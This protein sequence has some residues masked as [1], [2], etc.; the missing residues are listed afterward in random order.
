MASIDHFVVLMLENRSFDHV[1]GLR[2][3]VEGLLDSHGHPHLHNV[4]LGGRQVTAQGGAP[5][6][7]PTKH[8]RGPFHN[9][10]DV[11]EQL[12]ANQAAQ[13]SAAMS[14]FV[15]SYR[16]AL[17]SDTH[18]VFSNADVD[19]VMQA[20]DAASLPAI[21]ALADHFVLCD[22]WFCEVP[23]PTHPNRLY[24]HAGTSE[25]FAHN[26]FKR[27]FDSPTIYDLLDHHQRSW[28]VYDF[29]LNEVK[30]F[31]RLAAS[32]QNFRRFKPSFAQ[33]VQTGKLPNYSFIMPRY[34][35]THA[36]PQ[37]DQHPPADVR[38]G[39]HLI[40]DVY[41]TL[42]SRAEVWNRCALIVTYDE[43][44]GFYD[45]VP[46]PSA[47]NPDGID[48]P[49]PDDITGST[50]P[51]FAFDRLGVR[52]PALIVSP[53]VAKGQVCK[54]VLQ[55]TSI[56]KTVRE[57]FGIGQALSLREQAAASF[58]SVFSL[59]SPRTDTPAKLP[60]PKLPPL[61]AAT[62]HANPGNQFSDDLQRE[63]MEGL[64]QATRASH[65]E[66]EAHAPKVPNTQSDAAALAHQRWARHEKWVRQ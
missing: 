28:V 36:A 5:F 8:G 63:M 32:A 56:L 50:P 43:H 4:D 39:E 9:V 53:W 41:D 15:A 21:N 18:G 1:F 49:R 22:H 52:V 61:P 64:F 25:G 38:W 62:H 57:T 3:G 19:V 16:E 2:R 59:P 42:R 58:A 47:L 17:Q 10:V 6:A 29:D 48:S 40:A 20:F 12:F 44:G 27:P 24:M 14:G 30:N 34:L 65:P 45:H 11:N 23:G 35:S 13:G 51:K 31:T 33:D 55:H 54:G 26:V 66:D 7:I 46:P 37:T 60:R